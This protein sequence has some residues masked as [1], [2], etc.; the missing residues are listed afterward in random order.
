MPAPRRRAPGAL[1]LAAEAH[2]P[3][4]A[5]SGPPLKKPIARRPKR[6]PPVRYIVQ[7]GNSLSTIASAFGIK[8]SDLA[9]H[10]RVRGSRIVAGTWL[11]IPVRGWTRE[12]HR[13]RRGDTLGVIANRYGSTASA[14]KTFN[15]KRNTA[16]MIDERLIVYRRPH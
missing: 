8:V 10:N 6:R 2:R 5:A 4:P 16:I 15:G 7:R 11:K 9:A 13:V 14:L 3:P 1:R 12:V